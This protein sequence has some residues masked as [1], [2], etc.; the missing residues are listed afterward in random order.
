MVKN[1]LRKLVNSLFKVF[2]ILKKNKG[3][4]LDKSK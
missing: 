1:Q 2:A 4:N 3:S